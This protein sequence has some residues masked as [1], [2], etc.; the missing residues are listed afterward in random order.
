MAGHN[1]ISDIK[2]DEKSVIRRS[3]QVEHERK[4]AI[5][6]LLEENSFS[7]RNGNA[8]P[9]QLKLRIEDNRLIFDLRDGNNQHL[10]DISLPI[11][12]FRRIVK[13]YFLICDSYFEAI[14]T[15]APSQIEAIDMARRGLHNEGAD[16]LQER[17]AEHVD[18][19][20]QTARRLFTLIC[21]LHIRA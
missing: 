11:H 15:K 5:F 20:M 8:G 4:V 19:D 1:F 12:A 18:M 21:V 10:S 17:M 13:D 14:K 6:D 16:L 7:L 9:Y 3:P 2:L